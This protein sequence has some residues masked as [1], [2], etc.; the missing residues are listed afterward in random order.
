M[1]LTRVAELEIELKKVIDYLRSLPA[2]PETYRHANSADKVLNA[3]RPSPIYEGGKYTPAG[4]LPI[5]VRLVRDRVT[6]KA[7]HVPYDTE[8][9][10]IALYKSLVAGVEFHLSDRPVKEEFFD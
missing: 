7:T 9:H 2:H 4:L 1:E 5:A 3:S 10:A 6:I 8:R